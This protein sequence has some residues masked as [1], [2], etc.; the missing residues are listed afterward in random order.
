MV[1]L[2]P[3][4]L[5]TGRWLDSWDCAFKGLDSSDWV[6]GQRWVKIGPNRYMIAQKR[7]RWPFTET[8]T[9]MRDW[10]SGGGPYGQYV[11]QR[12]IED[13]ANGPAILDVLRQEIAGLKPINPKTSKEARA[14][15][16]TP[17]VE[18]GNVFLPYPRDPGKRWVMERLLPELRDFPNSTHDDQVDALTQALSEL[19]E[20]GTASLT[21]P[22]AGSSN[23][24]SRLD[25]Q[26]K[27]VPSMAQRS[28]GIS[29]RSAR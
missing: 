10:V 23:S 15:A 20:R 2:D 12:L 22:G 13:K 29:T 17:E 14:R 6:V 28:L 7:G 1:Y 3:D 16:V 24:A 27:R 18:S 26:R 25:T 21:V 19:R 8:L 5:H 9:A 4:T 11:H